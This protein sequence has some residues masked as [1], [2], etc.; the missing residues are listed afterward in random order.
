MYDSAP[1]SERPIMFSLFGVQ[2][3]KQI[4][5]HARQIVQ[6]AGFQAPS[7]LAYYTREVYR[8]MRLGRYVTVKPEE[9]Q[10]SDSPIARPR[11]DDKERKSPCSKTRS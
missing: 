7:Y 1:Q 8:G 5:V 9:T 11:R 3:A 4:G 6:A 10:K 2:Y